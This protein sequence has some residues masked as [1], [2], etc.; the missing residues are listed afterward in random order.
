MAK[1]EAYV[2]VT[3]NGNYYRIDGDCSDGFIEFL[4]FVFSNMHTPVKGA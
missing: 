1:D 3:H 4:Q 2:E